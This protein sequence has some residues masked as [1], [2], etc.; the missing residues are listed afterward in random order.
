MLGKKQ[1]ED[2]N[3]G[4]QALQPSV[5]RQVILPLKYCLETSQYRCSVANMCYEENTVGKG[6]ER[7]ERWADI[8]V[9][10]PGRAC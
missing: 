9:G 10:C 8:F 5:T 3:P 6:G 7:E 2:L 1:D 4:R